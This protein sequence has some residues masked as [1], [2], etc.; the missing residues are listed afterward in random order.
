MSIIYIS[1]QQRQQEPAEEHP[2]LPT[3]QPHEE[4][5]GL[6]AEFDEP[7][8]EEHM[9]DEE[10]LQRVMG[11]EEDGEYRKIWYFSACRR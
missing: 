4:L 3:Q 5:V 8:E 1:I 2:P 6:E 9:E 7:L 11:I 10:E